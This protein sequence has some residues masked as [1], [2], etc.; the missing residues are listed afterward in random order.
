[1]MKRLLRLLG[2]ALLLFLTLFAVAATWL[3]WYFD[4]DD[5]RPQIAALLSERTGLQ[6]QLDGELEHRVLN[7]LR[8]SI[9]DLRASHGAVTVADIESLTANLSLHDLL[10]RRLVFDELHIV[11]R[12][13]N[14]LTGSAPAAVA[15]ISRPTI[16]GQPFPVDTI[17][18]RKFSIELLDGRLR[19]VGEDTELHLRKLAA[20]IRPLPIMAGMEMLLDD[21]SWVMRH[22]Q[23]GAIRADTL[24][25]R[26]M[27]LKDLDLTFDNDRG[28]VA[29]QRFSMSILPADPAVLP[30]LSAHVQ[31]SGTVRLQF[32]EPEE[33]LPDT[34]WS[35]IDRVGL[36]GVE[37]LLNSLSLQ[38]PQGQLTLKDARIQAPALRLW[39]NGRLLPGWLS[40][41]APDSTKPIEFTGSELAFPG[42]KLLAFSGSMIGRGEEPKLAI[43][44]SRAGL[45]LDGFTN[46]DFLQSGSADIQAKAELRIT[47]GTKLP[48][49]PERLLLTRLDVDLLNGRLDSQKGPYTLQHARLRVSGIPLVVDG[50]PVMVD[51]PKQLS[52]LLADAELALELDKLSHRQRDIES[53]RLQLANRRDGLFV[54]HLEALLANT[55]LSGTGQLRLDGLR[56]PWSLRLES[57]RIA[58]QPLQ[59]FFNSP[60]EARGELTLDLALSGT[61]LNPDGLVDTLN[62]RL[63]MTG[64]DLQTEG[65]DLDMMLTHLEKSRSVGLLDLGAY[66]LAGPA[67]A[68]LS[69]GSDYTRLIDSASRKGTARIAQLHSELSIENGTV[70]TEDAAFATL[71]HR[72]AVKGSLKLGENGSLDLR[73]ATLDPAGCAR[74]MEEI[75][76]TV[77]Q[78]RVN[79]AGAVVKGVIDPLKSVIGGVLEAVTGGCREPFY[80][81]RVTA[82]ASAEPTRPPPAPPEGEQGGA[83]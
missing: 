77:A 2:W 36:G 23:Q 70:K 47:P 39:R 55:R 14:L 63:R 71:Q 19:K 83:D 11:A 65:I 52:R 72:V 31:G 16:S 46:E 59:A 67:G 56:H 76:G 74:Y 6:I 22:A 7:G 24:S 61:G 8:L 5:Y 64:R 25:L 75:G 81:G 69:K 48:T 12:G 4:L 79:Q 57:P 40:V 42:L 73:I 9:R 49:E 27:V 62:G 29:L 54:K 15:S 60:Y 78:P 45:L 28:E 50:A 33:T 21:P 30:A 3:T 17:T 37:L 20:E 80:Q 1:M 68:L 32:D 66:A 58:L 44:L 18:I 43:E 10:D 34:P 13:V 26:G 38:T 41:G 51:E 53:I 35:A 82:P